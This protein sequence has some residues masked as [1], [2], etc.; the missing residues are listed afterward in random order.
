MLIHPA[1]IVALLLY[2]IAGPLIVPQ[3][4]QTRFKSLGHGVH[5]KISSVLSPPPAIFEP[6]DYPF[7]F[8]ATIIEVLPVPSTETNV[9]HPAEV[10]SSFP[11]PLEDSA[12]VVILEV[13]TT[14]H[15]DHPSPAPT[16]VFVVS[17]GYQGPFHCCDLFIH[18]VLDVLTAICVSILFPLVVIPFFTRLFSRSESLYETERP[19]DVLPKRLPPKILAPPPTVQIRVFNPK[20][21]APLEPIFSPAPPVSSAF[22]LASEQQRQDRPS[23]PTPPLLRLLDFSALE[24]EFQKKR[25]SFCTHFSYRSD[26]SPVSPLSSPAD[27]GYGT[28]LPDTASDVSSLVP[29][30]SVTTTPEH[31]TKLLPTAD[32]ESTCVHDSNNVTTTSDNFTGE[33]TN[34]AGYDTELEDDDDDDG[35]TTVTSSTANLADLIARPAPAPAEVATKLESV[36]AAL[37]EEAEPLPEPPVEDLSVTVSLSNDLA[38]DIPSHDGPATDLP[39]NGDSVADLGTSIHE[40]VAEE[41]SVNICPHFEPSS[42]ATDAVVDFVGIVEKAAASTGLEAVTGEDETTIEDDLP[43]HDDSEQGVEFWIP[44]HEIPTIVVSPPSEVDPE[45]SIQQLDSKDEREE[46]EDIIDPDYEDELDYADDCPDYSVVSSPV[47]PRD[48]PCRSPRI[49]GKLWSDDEGDDLGPLPFSEEPKA[50]DVVE[51]IE[52]QGSPIEEEMSEVATATPEDSDGMYFTRFPRF[53]L[54][55]QTNGTVFSWRTRRRNG[56]R[57]RR[58]TTANSGS[59]CTGSRRTHPCRTC[60]ISKPFPQSPKPSSHFQVI[61]HP[62]PGIFR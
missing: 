60:P 31:L 19:I 45:D 18:R 25:E 37:I 17:P 62:H 2:W 30:E 50:T 41:I 54:E 38:A 14:Q 7:A 27:S 32:A 20:S 51:Q 24:N 12:E 8:E 28:T 15:D 9:V 10:I 13:S 23:S 61:S 58:G 56:P 44:G 11:V 5:Q 47:E 48:D 26:R 29:D 16:R 1:A 36:M 40:S 6:Q 57:T 46:S 4:F 21:H 22:W 3:R 43:S 35:S 33:Q 55:K 34:T 59:T 39:S 52:A 42:D 53:P 49:T